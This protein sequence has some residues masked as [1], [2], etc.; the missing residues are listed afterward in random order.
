MDKEEG[1]NWSNKE[2][3]QGASVTGGSKD[4]ENRL[5]SYTNK[6]RKKRQQIK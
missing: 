2:G 4:K 1:E 5:S 6:L 3:K